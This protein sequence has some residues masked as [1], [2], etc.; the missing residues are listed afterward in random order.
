V[1]EYAPQ[2]YTEDFASGAPDWS[3]LSGTWDASAGNYECTVTVS[4]AKAVYDGALWDTDYTYSL[5]VQKWGSSSGNETIVLYNYDDSSDSYYELGLDSGGGAELRTT[6]NGS[7][8]VDA[9]GTWSVATGFVSVVIERSG[10]ATTV[11]VGGTEIFSSVTQSDL[12]TGQIGVATSSSK[13]K[14]DDISVD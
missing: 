6:S 12:G 7:T 1:T 2:T 14:F 11:T 9:T 3:A 13:S 10:N 4:D 5:Q 8:S